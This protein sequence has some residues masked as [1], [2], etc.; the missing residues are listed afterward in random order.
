VSISRGSIPFSGLI[1]YF[2]DELRKRGASAL[3]AT[4]ITK[5][6]IL[7]GVG[8]TGMHV[9]PDYAAAK[10]AAKTRSGGAKVD[11]ALVLAKAG[12]TPNCFESTPSSAGPSRCLGERRLRGFPC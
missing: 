9:S 4:T 3:D 12:D 5:A 6:L 7:F 10:Q 8:A 2:Y 1:R 11:G